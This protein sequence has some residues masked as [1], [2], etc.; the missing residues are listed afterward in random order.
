MNIHRC[1]RVPPV[2]C[3]RLQRFG[4]RIVQSNPSPD[5][6][7]CFHGFVF[8][9]MRMNTCI[10]IRVC[11]HVNA[12]VQKDSHEHKQVRMRASAQTHKNTDVY[13]YS[14]SL[15]HTKQTH[16]HMHMHT[17][18]HIRT[19]CNLLRSYMRTTTA[20]RFSTHVIH[21]EYGEG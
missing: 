12:S 6:Q 18:A 19:L 2:D 11:M 16:I 17:H 7:I 21:F 10:S 15:S 4:H 8:R 3:G 20:T 13:T 5:V 14:L 1:V 9:R